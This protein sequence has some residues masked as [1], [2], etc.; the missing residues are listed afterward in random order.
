MPGAGQAPTTPTPAPGLPPRYSSPE[1]SGL[2][3][4]VRS[5][6]KNDFELNLD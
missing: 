6:A 4:E 1:T 3:F 5:E 2:E